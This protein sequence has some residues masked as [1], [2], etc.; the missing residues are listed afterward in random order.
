MLCR[1]VLLFSRTSQVDYAPLPNN[2]IEKVRAT[3]PE[4]Q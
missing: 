3:V 4:V 2:V 1:V